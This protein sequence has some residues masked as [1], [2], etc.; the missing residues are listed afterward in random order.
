MN[1]LSGH[2]L[3]VAANWFLVKKF[4][5][6]SSIG[7]FESRHSTSLRLKRSES[8]DCRAEARRRAATSKSRRASARTP[9]PTRFD[10][11]LVSFGGNS[12]ATKTAGYLDFLAFLLAQIIFIL[13]ESLA[14]AAALIFRLTF[15]AGFTDGFGPFSFAHLALAA[16]LILALAA[17]LI[18]HFFFGTA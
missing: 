13:A 1:V 14:L 5:S 3:C 9:R 12:H 2:C 10:L 7:E 4:R 6:A 16:A 18:F 17:L 8:E 15:L 11:I